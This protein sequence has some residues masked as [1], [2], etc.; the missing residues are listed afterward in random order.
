MC[1]WLVVGDVFPEGG[2][3]GL[4]VVVLGVQLGELLGCQVLGIGY[5]STSVFNLG[6]WGVAIHRV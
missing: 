1:C 5:C 2:Y 3:G 4:D 6:N